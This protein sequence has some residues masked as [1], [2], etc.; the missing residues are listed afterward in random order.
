MVMWGRCVFCFYLE[1]I[2][3]DFS[4]MSY[5]WEHKKLTPLEWEVE[6]KCLSEKK[7]QGLKAGKQ[8]FKR[9][10]FFK[11]WGF[12]K[13]I[14]CQKRNLFFVNMVARWSQTKQWGSWNEPEWGITATPADCSELWEQQSASPSSGVGTRVVCGVFWS[15]LPRG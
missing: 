11:D 10:D 7:M 8:F 14:W 13:T 4:R 15:P 3:S 6:V 12:L 1:I 5:W 9:R 2:T